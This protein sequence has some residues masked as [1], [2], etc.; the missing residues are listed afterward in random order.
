MDFI[1]SY[2]IYKIK[3]R[4]I[5]LGYDSKYIFYTRLF[6]F[7][8]H[9]KKDNLIKIVSGHYIFEKIVFSI[10]DI[11]MQLDD[12]HNIYNF[13]QENDIINILQNDKSIIF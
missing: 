3:D 5:K 12:Y 6:E 1:N 2:K 4:M 11:Y 7:I 8:L 9:K 10:M 13:S